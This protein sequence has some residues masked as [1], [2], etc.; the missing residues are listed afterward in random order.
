MQKHYGM[1]RGTQVFYASEHKG[2]LG[3]GIVKKT[4]KRK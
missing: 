4:K 1:K 2:I 3:K